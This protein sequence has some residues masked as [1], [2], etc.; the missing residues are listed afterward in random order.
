MD[1]IAA[2]SDSLPVQNGAMLSPKKDSFANFYYKT[3]GKLVVSLQT[4]S[5]EN[6]NGDKLQE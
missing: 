2:M 4:D 6:G 5:I 1:T 3:D